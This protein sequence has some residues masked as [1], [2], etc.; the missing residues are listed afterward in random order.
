MM[1]IIHAASEK[2]T[3]FSPMDTSPP[4]KNPMRRDTIIELS[5]STAAVA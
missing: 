2:P 1:M 5:V 4:R 3:A